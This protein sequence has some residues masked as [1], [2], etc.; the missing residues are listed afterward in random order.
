[1]RNLTIRRCLDDCATPGGVGLSFR[2]RLPC[3][4]TPFATWGFG[5]QR[6]RRI[7]TAR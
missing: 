2:Y 6:L 1:M 4:L 5:I 7:S 3:A